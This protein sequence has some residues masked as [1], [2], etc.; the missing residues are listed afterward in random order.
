M[1]RRSNEPLLLLRYQYIHQIEPDE[2]IAMPVRKIKE[3]LDSHK[4]KYVTI[5][6]SMACTAQ[7]IAVSAHIPGRELARTVMVKIG[8]RRHAT[9]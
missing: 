5:S 3:F 9:L 2:E 1:T 8:G 6:H 7:E 4:I